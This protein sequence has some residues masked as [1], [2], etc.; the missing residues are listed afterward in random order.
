[1]QIYFFR[2]YA[3]ICLLGGAHGLIFLPVSLSFNFSLYFMLIAM[4]D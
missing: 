2:M 4:V 1:M 3:L